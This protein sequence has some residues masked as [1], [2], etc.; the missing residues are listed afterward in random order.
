MMR[1]NDDQSVD[2]NNNQTW[3]YIPDNLYKI[4]TIG[5]LE[6]GKTNVLLNL[7][8]NQSW[9]NLLISQ[10]FIQMKVSIAY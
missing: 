1:K 6:S 3:P 7:I 4:L 5:G 2:I 10:R 8:N 9:Q